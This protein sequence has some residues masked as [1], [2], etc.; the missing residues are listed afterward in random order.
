MRLVSPL[1]LGKGTMMMMMMTMICVKAST[2]M[3]G[4]N[5]MPKR[6]SAYAMMW[7]GTVKPAATRV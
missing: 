4:A 5:A 1:A 7:A 2:V 3:G 6:V